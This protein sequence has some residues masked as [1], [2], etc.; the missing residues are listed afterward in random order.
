MFVRMELRLHP[1]QLM[2][3][4]SYSRTHLRRLFQARGAEVGSHDACESSRL[5][6]RA[7]CY[8]KKLRGG[9]IRLLEVAEVAVRLTAHQ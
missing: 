1:P 2:L 9:L 4:L 3:E 6:I 5:H 8:S 7:W